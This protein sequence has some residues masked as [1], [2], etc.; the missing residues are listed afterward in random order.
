MR[1]RLEVD[2]RSWSREVVEVPNPYMPHGMR[3]CPFAERA[4]LE[5]RVEVREAEDPLREAWRTALSFPEGK[6]LVIV[7]SVNVPDLAAFETRLEELNDEFLHLDRFLMGFHPEYGAED[8]ELDFL[9]EH[10]WESGVEEDYCMIFVQSLRQVVAYS[11]KLHALGYYDAFPPEEYQ[12]LVV[13]RKRRLTNGNEASR[14]EEEEGY[15]S[16][17]YGVEEE[18]HGPWRH[19]DQEAEGS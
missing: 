10:D 15:G 14:N 17:R 3:P 5:D 18:G 2:I 6:D 4:W 12:Q 16:R 7:A 1:G 9:Y 13:E 11:D 8:Q 19:G